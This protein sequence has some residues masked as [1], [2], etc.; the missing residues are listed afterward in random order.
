MVKRLY[1]R[2]NPKSLQSVYLFYDSFLECS[3]F[4]LDSLSE[5]LVHSSNFNFHLHPDDI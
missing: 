4:L 1:S 2:Y 3:F 5:D